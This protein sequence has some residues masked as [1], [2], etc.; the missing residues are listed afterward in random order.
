MVKKKKRTKK[1]KVKRKMKSK[2][3]KTKRV[4]KP[5][6]LVVKITTHKSSRWDYYN[7][8]ETDYVHVEVKVPKGVNFTNILY[9]TATIGA[10][11]THQIDGD[12][13]D[14]YCRNVPYT[15][16]STWQE[17]NLIEKNTFSLKPIRVEMNGW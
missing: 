2:K 13:C 14:E 15:E 9:S 5:K 6:E 16:Y 4:T 1:R 7:D 3:G 17:K 12:E 11:F 10:K 8:T